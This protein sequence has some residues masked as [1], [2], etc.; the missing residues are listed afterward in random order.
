M[1]ALRDPRH[2]IASLQRQSISYK[3]PFHMNWHT[4]E[5]TWVLWGTLSGLWVYVRGGAYLALRQ[6]AAEA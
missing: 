5:H 3:W 1:L 4:E 2:N 6:E